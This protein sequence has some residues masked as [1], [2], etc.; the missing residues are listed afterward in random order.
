MVGEP[1]SRDDLNKELGEERTSREP[2]GGGTD[3]GKGEVDGQGERRGR[4]YGGWTCGLGG[5]GKRSESYLKCG[6]KVPQSHKQRCYCLIDA[7][8]ATAPHRHHHRLQC[9]CSA[10]KP[11]GLAP[12]VFPNPKSL[13]EVFQL[14]L[15]MTT[16]RPRATAMQFISP[17]SQGWAWGRLPLWGGHTALQSGCPGWRAPDGFPKRLCPFPIPAAGC[18]SRG[19]CLFVASPPF[20]FPFC[21]V[22]AHCGFGLHLPDDLVEHLRPLAV[23]PSTSVKCLHSFSPDSSGFLTGLAAFSFHYMFQS[24]FSKLDHSR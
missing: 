17:A 16:G 10:W 21:G 13:S 5:H 19:L 20:F 12:P 15:N 1:V 8:K 11:G 14:K 7:L 3:L 6:H 24:H 22:A 23:W 9:S 2:S 4:K 18:E